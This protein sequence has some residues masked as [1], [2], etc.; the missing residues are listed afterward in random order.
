[1]RV[2]EETRNPRR[3]FSYSHILQFSKILPLATQATYIVTLRYNGSLPGTPPA[4]EHM[5]YRRCPL[6]TLR[7][8]LLGLFALLVIPRTVVAQDDKP[9]VAVLHFSSFALA[10]DVA[11]L[12]AALLDM[13]TTELGKKSSIR[14]EIGRAHV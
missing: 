3:I 11:D 1:M 7:I 9:T 2:S 14:V 8:G 12:G 5:M 6:R 4:P 13:V 10:R